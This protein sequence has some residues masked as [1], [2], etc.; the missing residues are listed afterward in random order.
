MKPTTYVPS[1]PAPG[2]G[3]A[4]C[5]LRT[6]RREF[7]RETGAAVAAI[8]ALLGIP[9]PVHALATSL[10]SPLRATGPEAV[11]P[12]PAADGATIDREREV[13]LVRWKG[14][15]YAFRL[16]CPHQ[17]TALKWKERDSRFQCPKHKS[18]YQPDGAFISGRAT[19]GMDRYAVR[20]E[21]AGIVV[22]LSKVFLQDKDAA[23]WNGA[24]VR[25]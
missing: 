25:V 12:L 14:S 24:A 21:G 3:C 6:G 2:A 13:I 9:E 18:K 17:K 15:V 5:E 10:V 16:S 8:A 11:Y 23:G 22:D 1:M 20:R 19:R 4:G 7:L